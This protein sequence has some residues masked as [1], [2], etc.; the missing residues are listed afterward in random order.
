MQSLLKKIETLLATE[1]RT[2]ADLARLWG[3]FGA[4][5]REER[6]ARGVSLVALAKRIGQGKSFVS[7]IETGER[8]CDMATAKVIVDALS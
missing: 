5:V 7:Y 4:A 1:A 3:E 2:T 6:E 8:R